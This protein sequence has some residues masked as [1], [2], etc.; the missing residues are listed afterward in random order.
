MTAF[1]KS[2]SRGRDVSCAAPIGGA[3]ED[4]PIFLFLRFPLLPAPQSI[5]PQID[6]GHLWR[7]EGVLFSAKM[8]PAFRPARC[9][10]FSPVLPLRGHPLACADPLFRGS[11]RPRRCCEAC[12]QQ[13]LVRWEGVWESGSGSGSLCSVVGARTAML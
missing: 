5:R 3:V 13:R 4:K 11:Q 10:H 7:L 6:G 1:S 2:E 12:G 8:V 9:A